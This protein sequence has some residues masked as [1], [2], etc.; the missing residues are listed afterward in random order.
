M[1][2][3]SIRTSI[4][5]LFSILLLTLLAS[6]TLSHAKELNILM[7]SMS[8]TRALAELESD[9]ENKTGIKANINIIEQNMF[10]R[11]MASS[12][13]NGN[14]AIDVVH[15]P[16][17]QLQKWINAGWL[18]PVSDKLEA[19][20]TKGDLLS[21]PLDSFLVND[22][23]WGIPFLAATSVMAYRKDILEEAGYTS[24]PKT[25][26]EVY[27]IAQNIH[28]EKTAGAAMRAVPGQGFNMFVYPQIMRAFGGKFFKNYPTDLT[29]AMNSPEGV[30]ALD[31]YTKLLQNYG[32]SGIENY[33]TNDIVAAM[34]SGKV[35]MVFD[36]TGP[37]SRILNPEKNKFIDKIEIAAIPEGP[38]G[39]FPAIAVH[40]MGIPM[41]AE[42]PDAAFAFIEW[43]T[44][45]EVATK[46]AMRAN[47]ADFTRTSVADNP[48]IIKKFS[49]IHP[50]FIKLKLQML[51][52]AIPH[53]RPLIE[54]WPAIGLVVG[55]N[56]N[57]AFNGLV[58][59]EEALEASDE[60]IAEI[61][62]K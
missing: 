29:P 58:T 1:N 25:W 40:G 35:A 56:I 53:Y 54:Q 15:V 23:Y 17:I 28:T 27:E 46:I 12:F 14:Q 50:N 33:N 22:S 36:G 62:N 3:F 47:F 55:E 49:E 59:S 60:D 34:H 18:Q 51:S 31:F 24:P 7:F 19:M 5:K 38:Y 6:T 45:E 11:S 52:E 13:N 42:N 8:Y 4:V 16:A 37:I 10:E 20:P 30:E 26:E 44:S 57:D 48:E 2:F 32:P 9:F 39:R 61:M 43:A 41:N 21:G